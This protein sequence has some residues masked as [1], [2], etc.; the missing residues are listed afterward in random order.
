MKHEETPQRLNRNGS[1][2]LYSVKHCF[3]KYLKPKHSWCYWFPPHFLISIFASKW[4]FSLQRSCNVLALLWQCNKLICIDIT[5]LEEYFKWQKLHNCKHILLCINQFC[6]IWAVRTWAWRW[7][8]S[9]PGPAC[10]FWSSAESA[11]R[12][13]LSTFREQNKYKISTI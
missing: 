6:V 11:A 12:G 4:M 13:L 7:I 3:W 9:Q 1:Y 2:N 8:P 10:L 5:C